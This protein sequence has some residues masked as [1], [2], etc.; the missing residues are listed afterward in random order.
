MNL[1]I[2]NDVGCY[3]DNERLGRPAI[4]TAGPF[5]PDELQPTDADV[6]VIV[7]DPFDSEQTFTDDDGTVYRWDSNLRRF[8]PVDEAA[9]GYSEADMVFAGE[10][11]RK[12]NGLDCTGWPV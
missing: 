10:R 12:R 3:S 1:P 6:Y 4:F 2:A 11:K 8:M 5:V 7:F 9:A